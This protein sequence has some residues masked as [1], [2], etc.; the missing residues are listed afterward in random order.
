MARKKKKNFSPLANI[1]FAIFAIW[2]SAYA[3]KLSLATQLKNSAPGSVYPNNEIQ[4]TLETTDWNYYQ[5]DRFGFTFKYPSEYIFSKPLPVNGKPNGS[6]VVSDAE[7]NDGSGG[8]Y[9][10]IKLPPSE[11]SLKNPTA[12]KL[13]DYMVPEYKTD[14]YLVVID[15]SEK[16]VINGRK[17]LKQKYHT[18]PLQQKQNTRLQENTKT[19]SRFVFFD[20]IKSFVIVN[21][22]VS[23]PYF[24]DQI[25]LTF[26]FSKNVVK[27]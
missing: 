21:G 10:T 12:K 19:L 18:T 11:D 27:E 17:A 25:A 15:S 7:N 8:P 23:H 6:I 24:L 16:L 22:D 3:L 9:I 20:G 2:I 4:T 13:E 14:K 1:V 26:D 5:D